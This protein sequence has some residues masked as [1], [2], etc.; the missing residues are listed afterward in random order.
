MSPS[1]A[2]RAQVVR[3]TAVLGV[4]SLPAL[5]APGVVARAAALATATVPGREYLAAGH[6]GLAY[7]LVPLVALSAT[8]LLLAPGLLCA[9]RLGRS[10]S[11]TEWIFTGFVCSL[12]LVSLVSGVAQAVVG[13]ALRGSAYAALLVVLCAAVLALLVPAVGRQAVAWPLATAG[14]RRDLVLLL[15]FWGAGAVGF[16]P[17]LLWESFNGDGAHAFESSRLL[18]RHALPFWPASAGPVAGFPGMTS[19]LYA[20]PNAWFLRLFGEIEYAAR[21]PLLVYVPVL[22]CGIR[23]LARTGLPNATESDGL[24]SVGLLTS[25]SA[26]ALAM[27]FSATYNPYSADMALPA[28]QDTLLMIVYVGALAA[29]LRAD[30]VWLALFVLLTYLSLPSGLILIGFWLAARCLVERPIPWR[31]LLAMGGMLAGAVVLS[32]VVPRLLVAAGSAPPG[33]EYGLVGILKYFAFLQFTDLTR[34]AYVAIPAGLFPVIGLVMWKAQDR[35]SRLLALVTIAY[36]LFFFV[37]AHISLH[38]FVPAM[39]LP[40]ALA[41]RQATQSPAG[42]LQARWWWPMGLLATALAFPW[43]RGAIHRDGREVG[44]ALTVRI[45][46][47]SASE[48][49]VMRATTVLDRVFAYDWDP[50]VPAV[51]GGSP[52]VWNHYARHA[53]EASRETNYILQ[54]STDPAPPGWRLAGSDSTGASLYVRSDAALARDRSRQ[55]ATPPGSR[56]LAVPRGILFH[57]VPLVGGPRLIDVAATLQSWGVDLE[58]LL[59]R[60]GVRRR[61]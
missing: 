42:V 44:A 34:L 29:S 23:E 6:A 21:I 25:L 47:Y 56:V 22:A 30:W 17:K 48:A 27:A 41:W 16:T 5:L 28:T 51:Y 32:A 4:A 7:G 15:L 61:S 1:I 57:S 59:A 40:M 37:Q 13:D 49:A 12:I 20:F 58:P 8:V 45:P 14:G 33:G 3:L 52:L 10:R 35:V 39:V 43:G 36:L 9:M 54:L 60:L 55:P 46:G 24:A 19:M 11:L 18:L 38:H 31:D 53:A 2:S 26:Y 50:A